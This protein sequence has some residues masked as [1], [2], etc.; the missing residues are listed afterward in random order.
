MN[1]DIFELTS[2]RIEISFKSFDELRH[3]LS[4]CQNN[5][6]YKIN[7]PCKNNL[8]KIKSTLSYHL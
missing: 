6:I 4:F 5:N 2:I 3:R 7:I 1:E 8:K